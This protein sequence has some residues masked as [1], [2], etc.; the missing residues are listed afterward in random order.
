MPGTPWFREGALST[1]AVLSTVLSIVR[2]R[3]GSARVFLRICFIGKVAQGSARVPRRF[4]EYGAEHRKVPRRFRKGFLNDLLC[5]HG[6]ARFREG[7]AS[8]VM[9][10]ATFREGFARLPFSC[11][12]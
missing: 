10:T 2:F 5:R 12:F 7:S 4:R 1:L 8:T 3:E 11:Q 9:S 6:S